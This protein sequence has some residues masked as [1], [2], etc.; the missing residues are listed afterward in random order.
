MPSTG[1]FAAP[2]PI[3]CGSPSTASNDY[4]YECAVS[5][6]TKVFRLYGIVMSLNALL[7]STQMGR[8]HQKAWTPCILSLH[9]WPCRLAQALTFVCC[10]GPLAKQNIKDRY[11]GVNDPVADK[12][13]NRVNAMPKVEAP[14]DPTVTTLYVGGIAPEV[15][16]SDLRDY[17]YPYGEI[18]SI[19]V[20]E[21]SGCATATVP[22]HIHRTPYEQPRQLWSHVQPVLP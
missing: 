16:E 14:E 11:Y 9:D 1:V 18:T 15:Q 17:F 21:S 19:K 3:R 4:P 7:W 8:D 22:V 5:M 13:L 10:A 6:S 12:M 2:C 20:R